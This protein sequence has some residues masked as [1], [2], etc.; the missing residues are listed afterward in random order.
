MVS[1]PPVP[2]PKL[3]KSTVKKK[4]FEQ[5][6]DYKCH[7]RVPSHCSGGWGT[8]HFGGF[9][10]RIAESLN[11]I[12]IPAAIRLPT[13]KCGLKK[14]KALVLKQFNCFWETSAVLF[15]ISFFKDMT[16]S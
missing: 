1:L 3:L 16:G 13:S 10:P 12:S 4:K 5:L 9:Y 11:K 15:G 7:S 2:A 6:L 8:W 14:S